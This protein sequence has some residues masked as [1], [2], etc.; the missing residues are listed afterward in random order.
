LPFNLT[1]MRA[2]RERRVFRLA[3]LKNSVGGGDTLGKAVA[4]VLE[5]LRVIY[6]DG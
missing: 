2:A 3:M 4:E 5:S 1:V 6:E